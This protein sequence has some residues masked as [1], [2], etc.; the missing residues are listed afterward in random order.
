MERNPAVPAATGTSTAAT[1]TATG[2][3]ATLPKTA[4]G[5]ERQ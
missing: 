2:T 3:S 4:V 5:R 1:I